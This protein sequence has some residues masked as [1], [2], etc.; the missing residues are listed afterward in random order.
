MLEGAPSAKLLPNHVEKRSTIRFPNRKSIKA[1]AVTIAANLA[2]TPGDTPTT[3]KH[4]IAVDGQV[5]V[6]ALNPKQ[7]VSPMK[8]ATQR[9]REDSY[10]PL[11]F[12]SAPRCRHSSPQS[13]RTCG[14]IIC[15]QVT[16]HHAASRGFCRRFNS[17]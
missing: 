6:R 11:A 5:G 7:L 1:Q 9:V 10:I 15:S 12:R 14:I 17:S 8:V 3:S 2:I 13:D 4:K 16:V